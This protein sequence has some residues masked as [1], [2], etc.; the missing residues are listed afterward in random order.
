M[1]RVFLLS[2]WLR[3]GSRL[4]RARSLKHEWLEMG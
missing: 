2:L 4:K 3:I 1:I